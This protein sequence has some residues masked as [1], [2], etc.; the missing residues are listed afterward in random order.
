MK[1]L[2]KNIT[3]EIVSKNCDGEIQGNSQHVINEISNLASV[4]ATSLSFAL[5]NH[6]KKIKTDSNGVILIAKDSLIQTHAF[7]TLIRVQN[8]QE[9]FLQVCAEYISTEQVAQGVHPTAQIADSS[10]LGTNVSVGAY[11]CIAEKTRIGA[12]TTIGSQVYVGNNVQIGE[13]CYIYPGVKILDDS[14]LGNRIIIH[15]NTVIGSD[16]FGYYKNGNSF[17]KI[18]HYGKVIIEDDV[19]IGSNCS[20]DKAPIDCTIIRKAA[21][22]DNLIHIAHGVEI[23]EGVAIAAQCGIAG[24]SIIGEQSVLGG[25]VGIAGHLKIASGSQIQGKSGIVS[26]IKEANKKWYG[27]PILGYLEYLRSYAIFKKLPELL[28]RLENLEKQKSKD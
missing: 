9:A 20:I 11:S 17:Q 4:S 14:I 21:K 27:Y 25:Q 8:P 12:R 28:K 3:A 15:A 6:E 5:L 1:R 16:G 19:E 2:K 22:L 26:H 23:G 7:A 13:D 24:S 18:N 10:H